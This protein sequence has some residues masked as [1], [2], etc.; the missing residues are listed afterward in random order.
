MKSEIIFTKKEIALYEKQAKDIDTI[1]AVLNMK[2]VKKNI[3]TIEKRTNKFW[4]FT[5]VNDRKRNNDFR[6]YAEYYSENANI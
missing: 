5:K 2:W 3:N 6:S 1:D 4:E